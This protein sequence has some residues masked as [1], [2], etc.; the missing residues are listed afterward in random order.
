MISGKLMNSL[1]SRIEWFARLS[2]E[3]VMI[4][5]WKF[6]L[7][8][9]LPMIVIATF[10]KPPMRLAPQEPQ[11]RYIIEPSKEDSPRLSDN[12][13]CGTRAPEGNHSYGEQLVS[14]FR[15]WW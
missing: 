2:A 8:A 13:V 9:L 6:C 11:A 3:T 10:I 12:L 4:K 1:I 14:Y 5:H 15:E 7:T